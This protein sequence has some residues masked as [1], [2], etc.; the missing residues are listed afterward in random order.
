MAIKVTTYNNG[1][2][3]QYYVAGIA[4]NTK[5]ENDLMTQLN[6]EK[7][8]RGS[9]KFLTD[10]RNLMA[11]MGI[12]FEYSDKTNQ[13]SAQPQQGGAANN[14]TQNS[15][16]GQAAQVPAQ[17][18]N[19]GNQQQAASQ[20]QEDKAWVYNNSI[21]VRA[22]F[23]KDNEPLKNSFKQQFGA[24]WDKDKKWWVIANPNG[25]IQVADVE[26]FL[27]L[28]P[29]GAVGGN[30]NVQQGNSMVSEFVLSKEDANKFQAAISCVLNGGT[31][32]VG[33]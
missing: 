7:T 25:A 31:L 19:G 22:G 20:A 6:G 23:L 2:S 30:V 1:G 32:R 21:Q 11:Q 14:T 28:A 15:Q 29:S 24:R 26:N 17:T 18:Y 5:W 13:V 12:K 27:G 16:G 10:P 33:A 4:P 3:F 8:T 9:L